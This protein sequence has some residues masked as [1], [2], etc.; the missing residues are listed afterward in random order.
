M[1]KPHFRIPEIL[2]DRLPAERLKCQRPHKLR[3]CLSHHDLNIGA[4]FHEQT[5][6]FTG[7]V[8]GDTACDA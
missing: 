7:F 3:S 2:C 4:G 5:E 8:C 6:K 1:R